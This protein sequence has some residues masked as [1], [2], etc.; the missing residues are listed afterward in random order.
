MQAISTYLIAMLT[1]IE[2]GLGI[3][4]AGVLAIGIYQSVACT[5]FRTTEDEPSLSA[6]LI[7]SAR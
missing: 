3:M 2:V 4:V 7:R 6:R 1:V 5:W